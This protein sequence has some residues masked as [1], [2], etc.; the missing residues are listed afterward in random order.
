MNRKQRDDLA[1]TMFVG[2]PVGV[3]LVLILLVLLGVP[4]SG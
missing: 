4:I 3:A 2:L 1:F